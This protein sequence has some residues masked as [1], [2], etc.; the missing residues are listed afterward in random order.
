MAEAVL[1]HLLKKEG[2]DLLVESAGTRDYH[3][4]KNPNPKTMKVLEENGIKNF[5]HK[6]R[7]VHK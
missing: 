4:G 6:A 5:I 3:V 1:K 2:V 7:Q